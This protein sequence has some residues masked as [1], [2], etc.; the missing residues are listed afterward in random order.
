[1]FD[2]KYSTDNVQEIEHARIKLL[3]DNSENLIS[4]IYEN[5]NMVPYNNPEIRIGL[6]IKILL[7]IDKCFD[8]NL[9]NKIINDIEELLNDK[10]YLNNFV[11]PEE[12]RNYL[13]K[14]LI[15]INKYIELSDTISLNKFKK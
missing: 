12:R 4:F 11:N 8:I 13:E 15:L 7:K 6:S 3:E 14:E 2:Y 1:M 10:T 9:I 5:K